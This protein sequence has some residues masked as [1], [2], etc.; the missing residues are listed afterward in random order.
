MSKLRSKW[1][2]IINPHALY[3]LGLAAIALIPSSPVF[4]Q[5]PSPRPL[6]QNLPKP[7]PSPD[8][9]LKPPSPTKLPSNVEPTETETVNV[10]RFEIVGN[11]VFSN[12]EL[13]EVL[14]KF[15][16]RSLTF[17]ELIQARSAITD[18]YIRKG[19]ITSGAYIPPQNLN[20]DVVISRCTELFTHLLNADQ[21]FS[22]FICVIN[23]VQLLNSSCRRRLTRD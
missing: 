22:L 8:E 9:L 16:N 13:N 11:T 6:P 12:D 23:F 7:L 10:Q 17:S 2:S 15:T 20:S 3:P 21:S 5:I 4:A 19:Y 14:A 1:L 18:L